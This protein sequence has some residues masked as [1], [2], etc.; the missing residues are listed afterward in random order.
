MQYHSLFS[1]THVIPSDPAD[2]FDEI[3]SKCFR[4]LSF[5]DLFRVLAVVICW[6]HM[7]TQTCHWVN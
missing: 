4:C 7:E 2:T 5:Q 3:G 1:A 6:D